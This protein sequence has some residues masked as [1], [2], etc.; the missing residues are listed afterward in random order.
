MPTLRLALA[1]LCAA[2]AL[3]RAAADTPNIVYILADDLGPGDV[4]FL[5]PH[6]AWKTPAMDRIAAAGRTFTDAHSASAVCTPSRYAILTGRYPWRTS[7]KARVLNGYSAPLID[8][9]RI[10]VPDLLHTAGYRTAGVGKWHLG[11]D[12]AHD[13][14]KPQDVDFTK[15]I[16]FGPVQCGFDSYFGI[17]AS[18]D[19]PPYVYVKNEG[20]ESPPTHTVANSPLPAFYRAGVAAAGFSHEDVLARVTQAAIRDLDADAGQ[21]DHRPFFLYV[22]L[23]APHTP[24]IPTAEWRGRSHVTPYGDFVLEVDA[25]V[26]KISAELD[27]LHLASNTLVVLT[28]DNGC[29]TAANLPELKKFGHDP[30][31]GWRGQKADIFEGGHRIP[32]FVRWPGHVTAGSRS[33]ALI[34]QTDLIATLAQ[35][36]GQSLPADGAE[37]SVSMLSLL[38]PT[39]PAHGPRASLVV[40]SVNGSLGLRE[41]EWK[42]CACPDSGGWS[43]PKPGPASKFLPPYQLF[44]L[45][46]DPREQ[47]NL[48]DD[49]P[50]LVEKFGRELCEDVIN[51]RTRAG[52][53]PHTAP[54]DFWPNIASLKRFAPGSTSAASESN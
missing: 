38:E 43:E 1:T 23:T 16:A 3:G 10:T 13:G 45:A 33:D 52:I 8:R 17:P 46:T 51:G 9:G 18:L 30:S 35:L 11:L 5:N 44:N 25:A 48:S 49:R 31:N 41:G 28:S 26:G 39:L 22:A 24:I 12:W 6:S 53:S 47:H 4:S 21:G 40:A 34:S 32:F 29:S 50:D 42:F 54:A 37:D 15:P 19:M 7:L 27:R 20:V 14:P 2:L 36:T